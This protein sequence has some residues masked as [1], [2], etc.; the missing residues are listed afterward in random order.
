MKTVGIPKE[1]THGEPRVAAT[2]ETVKKLIHKGCHVLLEAGAGVAAGFP[3]SDYLLPELM[4][5]VEIV[6]GDEAFQSDIVLKINKPTDAEITRMKKGAL[7]ISFLEPYAKDST[8]ETL[9]TRGIDAMAMELI[10]RTSRGQS[11]DALSSQANLGGYKAVIEAARIYGRFFP[12]MMTS[13]GSAKPAKVI[14]LGAG[15][16]GLQAIGTAKRLGANVFAYDIRPEV[17]EQIRSLGAKVI[18]IEVGEEGTGQGGYA[19]QLSANAAAE[20]QRILTESL[21]TADVIIS[22]ANVPGRKAPV[23]ITEEAVRGMRAGSVIVDMA[24]SSGGNCPL[25]EAGKT[26]TKHGVHLVGITNFPALMPA[27]AS[28]FYSRNVL[29]LLSL[30]LEEKDG[31]A[32]LNFNLADDIIA[33]SLAV[34]N[35]EQR[36]HGGK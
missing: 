35:G 28:S 8:L 24:A 21:K 22:T 17:K 23:L 27:D 10:P 18:E 9:A 2:P 25:T 15:V 13:A 1:S 34:L 33:A 12:M 26:V 30:V 11:M 20:Q 3:D 14:V 29:N 6:D 4:G 36:F 16:A 7:L 19:K 31:N 32:H 5:S